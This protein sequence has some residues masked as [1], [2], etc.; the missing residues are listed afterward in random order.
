MKK[1]MISI[2][3]CLSASLWGLKE[4]QA[5]MIGGGFTGFF[6]HVEG[7][8]TS[9]IKKGATFE[10]FYVLKSDLHSP[11]SSYIWLS[12][13]GK[14]RVFRFDQTAGDTIACSL[15]SPGADEL[16]SGPFALGSVGKY[17]V[18][19]G[20]L[21]LPNVLH[22][23]LPIELDFKGFVRGELVLLFSGKNGSAHGIIETLTVSSLSEPDLSPRLPDLRVERI[24]E[25]S[26]KPFPARDQD[27]SI[28]PF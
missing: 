28:C 23:P 15:F 11:S 1:L 21:I 20:F 5:G 9:E 6:S 26:R 7:P 8:V 18:E 14:D 25:T 17:S 4:S 13:S 3:C 12:L 27:V 16:I 22:T 19:E 10:G 24:R 2:L